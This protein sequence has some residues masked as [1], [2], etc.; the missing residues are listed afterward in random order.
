MNKCRRCGKNGEI[1]DLLCYTCTHEVKGDEPT[2]TIP[3]PRK[4]LESVK[5]EQVA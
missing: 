3:Q 1:R 5:E 2:V 4:P